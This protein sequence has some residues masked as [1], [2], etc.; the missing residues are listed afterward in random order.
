M[1]AVIVAFGALL[2]LGAMALSIELKERRQ[3]RDQEHA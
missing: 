3:K 1:N 2:I